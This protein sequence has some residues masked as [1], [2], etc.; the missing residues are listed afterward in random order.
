MPF[1]GWARAKARR[2]SIAPSKTSVSVLSSSSHSVAA[3][4]ATALFARAKPTFSGER[5][6][7]TCGKAAA[8]ASAEP[9]PDA[10]SQTTVRNRPGGRG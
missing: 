3:V 8:T 5:I 6:S 1:A 7:S 10:L 9:S 4:S 2:L